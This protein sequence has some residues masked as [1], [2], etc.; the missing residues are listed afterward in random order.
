MLTSKIFNLRH[1]SPLLGSVGQSQLVEGQY[2]LLGL[3]SLSPPIIRGSMLLV[4]SNAFINQNIH[5]IKWW[6]P[7]DVGGL[8][9]GFF[10]PV[11]HRDIARCRLKPDTLHDYLAAVQDLSPN[12]RE[13]WIVSRRSETMAALTMA[14]L[15]REVA[16]ALIMSEN[17]YRFGPELMVEG[18]MEISPASVVAFWCPTTYVEHPIIL[19]TE[20]L[21]EG[22]MHVYDAKFG[23]E[24]AREQLAFLDWGL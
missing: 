21:L 11:A 9:A 22:K 10:G 13:S 18:R 23:I 14:L 12:E 19:R 20:K 6:S 3:P 8:A 17:P 16:R 1:L 4:L 15:P 24:Q 7:V 5:S 2:F